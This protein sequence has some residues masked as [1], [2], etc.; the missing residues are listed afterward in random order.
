MSNLWRTE[1]KPKNSKYAMLKAKQTNPEPENNWNNS[2]LS[3]NHNMTIY[4]PATVSFYFKAKSL[5][6]KVLLYKN[7][8]DHHIHTRSYIKSHKHIYA[9]ISN[10]CKSFFFFYFFCQNHL[11]M[12]LT[13]FDQFKKIRPL[14]SFSKYL[15]NIT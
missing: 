3:S 6:K 9:C 10:N 7:N 4:F 14:Y 13:T 5:K 12:M 15:A 11:L 8:F 1:K 2:C